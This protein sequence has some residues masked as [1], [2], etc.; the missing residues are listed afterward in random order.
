[1]KS[2]DSKLSVQVI[3]LNDNGEVLAVS[4]KDNHKD[5]GLIGGKV[6]PE[7]NGDFIAAAIREAKEETGLDIYNLRLVFAMHKDGYMGYTF[8]ADFFGEITTDEPHIVKWVPFI[9]IIDNSSFG[10]WNALVATS[11]KNAGITFK[12][13]SDQLDELYLFGI[14]SDNYV[15]ICPK[16]HWDKFQDLDYILL[17]EDHRNINKMCANGNIMLHEAGEWIYDL[18]HRGVH[19]NNKEKIEELLIHAGFI[20]SQELENSII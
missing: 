11:L 3:L 8:L 12:M 16:T 18:S 4:R 6:D 20:K 2:I 1:M 9:Q 7:D 15:T 5:F 10:E 19:I 17:P 14:D 13:Y